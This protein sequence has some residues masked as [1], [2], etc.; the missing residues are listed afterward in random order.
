MTVLL[1]VL[2]I[3]I[4]LLIGGITGYLLDMGDD[5]DILCMLFWPLIAVVSIVIGILVGVKMLANIIMDYLIVSV[6]DPIGG[7]ISKQI[8]SWRNKEDE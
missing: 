8:D 2:G 4:Y 3:F 1:I 6:I 7:Y 5:F